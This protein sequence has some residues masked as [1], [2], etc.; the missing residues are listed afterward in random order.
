MSNGASSVKRSYGCVPKI[1]LT[2]K[3]AF[4]LL[5]IYSKELK[6]EIYHYYLH[7]FL[8]LYTIIKMW[9]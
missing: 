3:S 5:V 6:V 2:Y 1:E 4:K 7:L 8:A 9:D